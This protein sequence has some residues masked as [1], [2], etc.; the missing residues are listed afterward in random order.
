MHIFEAMTSCQEL[1][2]THA[3]DKFNA[4]RGLHSMAGS[5][6]DADYSMSEAQFFETVIIWVL[7][8]Y[9]DLTPLMLDLKRKSSTSSPSWVPDLGANLSPIEANYWKRRIQFYQAYACSTGINRPSEYF[10]DGVLV[11]HGAQ[12]DTVTSVAPIAFESYKDSAGHVAIIESWY[13]F[14]TDCLCSATRGEMFDCDEFAKTMLAGLVITDHGTVREANAADLSQ[15][16]DDMSAMAWSDTSE[17]F[18][19]PLIESHI[20][21]ALGR[22]LFKTSAGSIAVGP[23]KVQVGDSLWIWNDAKTP[24]LA[25][26][27]QVTQS[28]ETCYTFLGH[29]YHHEW[30]HGNRNNDV[31]GFEQE[32]CILV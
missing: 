17:P 9:R 24:V 10:G 8:A 13:S 6:P 18:H 22:V 16:R 3:V 11:M 7:K 23:R 27:A 19:T 26:R 25:R 5:L 32:S 31:V 21:A 4:Y 12:V 20:T 30:S 15:W 2:V 28:V 29:F 1:H 14:A